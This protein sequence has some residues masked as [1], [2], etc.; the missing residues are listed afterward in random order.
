[1]Q[2]KFKPRRATVLTVAKKHDQ[3]PW[4]HQDELNAAIGNR[5]FIKLNGDPAF[6]AL[7]ESADQFTIKVKRPDD[8]CSR[9]YF[10]HFITW[11]AAPH[12]NR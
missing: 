6:E 8:S 9:V 1:M 5:I 3:K 11:F 7:L 4:S 2:P 12:K 10:K